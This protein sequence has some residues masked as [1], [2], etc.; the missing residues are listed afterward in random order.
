MK[1][2]NLVLNCTIGCLLGVFLGRAIFLFLDYHF[3]PEIYA[4][5]S[6]PWYYELIFCGIIVAVLSAV[7]L[8]IKLIVLKKLK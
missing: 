3:N 2:I 7:V 6:A 8:I 1:H 5:Y 4:L